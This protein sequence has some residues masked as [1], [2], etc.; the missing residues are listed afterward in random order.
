MHKER[1]YYHTVLKSATKFR[2]FQKFFGGESDVCRR[3]ASEVML[4]I[5]MLRALHAVK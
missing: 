2:V 1:A 5:V 4:C 3:A